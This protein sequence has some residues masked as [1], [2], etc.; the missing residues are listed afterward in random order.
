MSN[1]KMSDT[2]NGKVKR[3]MYDDE[4]VLAD[5]V[6]FDLSEAHQLDAMVYAI[7]SHDAL[8]ARV[9]ELEA[10]LNNLN[11]IKSLILK[12][13]NKIAN[14]KDNSNIEPDHDIGGR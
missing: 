5:N 14:K 2:F 1:I 10:E 4:S 6:Y 12:I 11:N 7:N 3:E 13:T 9:A 8:T